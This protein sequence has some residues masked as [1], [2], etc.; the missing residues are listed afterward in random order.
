MITIPEFN[1]KKELYNYLVTNKSKLIAQKKSAIKFTDGINFNNNFF[2]TKTNAYKANNPVTEDVI[3]LKVRVVMNTT[4]L[5]DSHKDVHMPGIWDKT[6]QENKMLMHVR[7]HQSQK[8]DYIISDGDDLKA[9]VK[10]MDWSE[11]GSSYSGQSQAL[12]FDSEI[13]TARNPF[14][15]EQYKK[16]YVKN[17]SVG[18]QYVKLVMCIND[19]DY[20]AEFEAW[21]KYFPFVANSEDAEKTGYFWAVTEAKLS[22]GSAVVLGSNQVTP[23]L[24]NNLKNIEPLKNT[25]NNE[26]QNSTQ[27]DYN[28]LL[29]NL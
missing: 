19:K 17:H 7:E 12:I 24:D 15:L 6:L 13:K 3:N 11:L 25:Q 16:G 21:E 4:N 29:K 8:F 27:I 18:M 10:Y 20:G 5:M 23:T 9:Y 14:M 1:T 22:E 2:D 26:P 28:Y